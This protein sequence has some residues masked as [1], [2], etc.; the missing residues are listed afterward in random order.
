MVNKLWNKHACQLL[1][2]KIEGVVIL[3]RGMEYYSKVMKPSLDVPIGRVFLNILN[4]NDPAPKNFFRSVG[5]SILT[6]ILNL[7]GKSVPHFQG[8][9]H[10]LQNMR[11]FSINLFNNRDKDDAPTRYRKKTTASEINIIIEDVEDSTSYK[12]IQLELPNLESVIMS[13]E[14]NWTSSDLLLLQTILRGAPN[15]KNLNLSKWPFLLAPTL[16]E[17]VSIDNLQFLTV[18]NLTD[19]DLTILAKKKLHLKSAEFHLNFDVEVESFDK[20][21]ESI[22]TTLEY[23][24]VESKTDQNLKFQLHHKMSRLINIRLAHWVGPICLDSVVGKCDNL[25][26]L[27]LSNCDPATITTK[28]LKPNPSVKKLAV[29]FGK[30]TSVSSK[31][32]NELVKNFIFAFPHLEAFMMKQVSDKTVGLIVDGWPR[33]KTLRVTSTFGLT[34]SSLTGIPF[35][36]LSKMTK[37]ENRLPCGCCLPVPV[38]NSKPKIDSLRQ[39][40]HIGKLKGKL[41]KPFFLVSNSPFYLMLDTS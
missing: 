11:Q 41:T 28:H 1:R 17:K 27:Q 26:K 5:H 29:S 16:L 22:S 25:M 32:R 6:L 34:D 12:P 10:H 36:E 18:R 35:T 30:F 20:F 3:Q 31:I 9:L 39:Y 19:K 4:M 33:L 24:V 13:C 2:E 21:I 40:P 7:E 38:V 14:N 23:L 15:V 8:V 37:I